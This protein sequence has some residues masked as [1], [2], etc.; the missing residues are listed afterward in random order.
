VRQGTLFDE[1]QL[2]GRGGRA[3]LIGAVELSR[4]LGQR[5]PPTAEQV[6]AIEHVGRRAQA[7]DRACGP[8]LAPYLVLAGAGSGKTETMAARVVWLV[9]NRLVRPE[10][11]LGLTFTRKAAGE[12]GDRVR[13]RLRQLEAHGPLRG[14]D[15]APPEDDWLLG[16]PTVSTYHAYA[17]RL[18]GEHAARIGREPSVRLL[19]EASTWQYAGRVVD[20]YDGDMTGVE[21]AP[22]T[23]VGAVRALAG[24]LAEHLVS[25][26][27]VR[28][29]GAALSAALTAIPAHQG[30]RGGR[31]P[32][33]M[34]GPTQE[35]LTSLRTRLA[36]LPLVEA[37]GR[38]KAL[39]EAVDYGDQ[40]ALAAPIAREHPAVGRLEK[41]RYDVILLDEYQDTGTAQRVLLTAV[42]GGGHPVTAVGDP[43]Q[44]IYGWRGASAG[45]L[46]RFAR[47][48]PVA[49][50]TP[51]EVVDLTTSFRNSGRILAVANALSVPLRAQGVPV[52]DLV[53]GPKGPESG[54]VIHACLSDV[55]AEA[56]WIA[57]R[58]EGLVEPA[59]PYEPREIAVLARARSQFE[60]IER[61]LRA[62]G[63]P[64]EVSGL[65]G[66][67]STPEVTD[68]VATLRV[69]SDPTAGAE[70]LRLLT[71][72][73][74]RLGPRD[75]AALAARARALARPGP[76]VVAALAAQRPGRASP[77][78]EDA[79]SLVE[80]LD[81][82]GPRGAYSAEG[83]RRMD[84]LRR[85]L[86][87][88]RRRS[89]QPLPDL[90]ADVIR[91][92]GIDV[93]VAAHPRREASAARGH[94]DRFLDVAAE[95]TEAEDAP[96]TTAFLAYLEAASE[97]ERG[98]EIGR[99][100]VPGDAVH[101][102]T[103]HGAKGLEWPVVVVPGLVKDVF[104]SRSRGGI[105]WCRDARLLPFPLRGDS[106]DLPVLDLASCTD[107]RDVRDALT[108]HATACGERE[109]LEERRLL[110]VAATRAEDLLMCT[111]YWW[112]TGTS[113]RGPSVFLTEIRD[114]CAV[115]GPRPA[116]AG[117]RDGAGDGGGDGDGDW[118]PRPAEGETNPKAGVLRA[119]RWPRDPLT[120]ARRAA[121][122]DGVRR[123]RAA[124]EGAAG[125]GAAGPGDVAAAAAA[126][127]PTD[128]ERAAIWDE[129]VA[130]L[131]AE[132]TGLRESSAGPVEVA[133]PGHLSVSQLVALRQD[134][135]ELARWIRRPV[136]LPPAP[137]AR[138]GTAFHS[139]LEG[140][141]QGGRLLDIDELPG[142][143]D[144]DAAIDGDLDV[145]K[146]AFLASEWAHRQ[147]IEVE[148]PFETLIEDVLVRGR[149]DAVFRDRAGPTDTAFV[150]VVVDWKTGR[151]PTGEDARAAAVQLAAYRLA[152]H[153][154][155]G[156]PLDRISAAFH[157]VRTGVTVRP[158]DLLDADGL[159]DLIRRV[160]IA[161]GAQV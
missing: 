34:Y 84:L 77:G 46:T 139:W 127:A 154:L 114:A 155:C 54:R 93:E 146:D 105:D 3:R 104:P 128:T 110:Y 144:A 53:P 106:A 90:I 89:N 122:E 125:E 6:R 55:E 31:G 96:T 72:A 63:V 130:K 120:P 15:A 143:A 18:V 68:V 37:F 76:D 75:L 132:R 107:Q 43:C 41:D 14:G 95:F 133:L 80:A 151:R 20:S 83:Y 92:I 148:V 136:P 153:R 62:R 11:I 73:R 101:L 126:L 116:A 58:I 140:R 7:G 33:G 70:V 64:V 157:Y 131:L 28:A 4:R 137:L 61:A 25:V 45:N 16:D 1:D 99:M 19:R 30:G 49:P 145:L 56:A 47:D 161:S 156:T 74:W 94:L 102:L 38:R 65:G 10:R 82:L 141:F 78:A 152:W 134:P 22:S 32:G 35:L 88:L 60:P 113:L 109:A 158:V 59:G 135:D 121:L 124:G 79:G 42:F 142:A 21:W 150:D 29:L 98:L 9:A 118:A 159:V 69:M 40:V 5:H 108:A 13:S 129:E 36:L 87:G 50:G 112:S 8:R 57:D 67:L 149:A 85:E 17:G 119:S 115:L 48:F 24:D 51:S 44:S 66:L 123:V 91:T 138:R 100:G 117:E 12:L 147:P 111:G 97:Y 39:A 52:R 81:D 2:R 103:V 71:G 160:P 86:H 27:D 23:V 26:E